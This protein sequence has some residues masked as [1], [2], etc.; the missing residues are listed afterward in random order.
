MWF[1]RQDRGVGLVEW[2][3]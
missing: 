1:L 2:C 3:L